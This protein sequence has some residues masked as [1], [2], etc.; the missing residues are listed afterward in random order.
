MGSKK[1]LCSLEKFHYDRSRL[2]LHSCFYLGIQ[3]NELPKKR[4]LCYALRETIA[5]HPQLHQ[6][7]ALN[8]EDNQPY[9]KNIDGVIKFDDIAEYVPFDYAEDNIN[10]IF[11][12]QKFPYCV[13]KPLWKLL[14][15]ESDTKCLLLLDHTLFDGMSAVAFWTSF[16]ES[17]SDEAGECDDD[18]WAPS[19][20]SPIQDRHVYELWPTTWSSLCKALLVGIL[21]RLCPSVVMAVGKDQLRFKK[22]QFPDGLFTE[23]GSIGQSRYHIRNDNCQQS[24]QVEPSH[25]RVL[26]SACKSHSVSLTSFLAALFALS[27]DKCLEQDSYTGSYLKIDVPMNT[28]KACAEVLDIPESS[29][30]MGNFVAPTE[31]RYDLGTTDDIWRLAKELNKDLKR[32]TR[33]DIVSTIN[34]VRLLD[35]ADTVKFIEEKIKA[36]GPSGTF[37]ITNLGTQDFCKGRSNGRFLVENAM[38]NEPQS[39]SD[40]FTCSVISTPLGGLSCSLSYPRA[41][42][43][44]IEPC[45]DDL[46]EFLDQKRFI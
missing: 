7:I 4:L 14:I 25:L 22:Y 40:V 41:V 28:R 8:L 23:N 27:M 24:L 1:K 9:I 18:L 13:E 30:M 17:L 31:L 43:R 44:T 33:T 15:L 37:E 34:N 46:K 36:D 11:R 45:I 29:L 35:V 38:F 10:Q 12:D 2:N 42:K 32:Q 5:K 20:E 3:L 16:M 26:L 6:T 19:Q 39:I 21:F